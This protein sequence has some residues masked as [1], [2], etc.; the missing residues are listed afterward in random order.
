[1]V[2]AYW[3][4]I[5]FKKFLKLIVFNAASPHYATFTY[6]KSGDEGPVTAL[7]FLRG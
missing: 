4:G 1:M 6:K 5:K 7:V 3:T 2:S